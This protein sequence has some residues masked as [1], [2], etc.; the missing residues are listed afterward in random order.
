MSLASQVNLALQRIG[1]EFK[2]VRTAIAGKA[3]TLHTHIATTDLTATGTKDT[4]TYLRGDNTWTVPPNS[5]YSPQTQVEAESS[6]DTTARLTTGQRLYQA[7]AK[8][9]VLLTDARLVTQS[10][11]EAQNKADTTARV[12]T[13]QRLFQAIDFHAPTKVDLAST[14]AATAYTRVAYMDGQG[15]QN[16][17]HVTLLVTNQGNYG[18]TTRCASLIQVNQRGTNGYGFQ[19]DRFGTASAGWVWYVVTSSFIVEV[20]ALRPAFDNGTVVVLSDNMGIVDTTIATQAGAPA[21]LIAQ[22]VPAAATDTVVRVV[23]GATAG[24]AR[25]ATTYV[26]WV[27]SVSPTNATANDTWVNTSP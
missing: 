5:T 6:S 24:A 9:A 25:P 20:W 4:T 3:N 16:G 15:A 18:S 21:G 8:W 11:S 13:G 22:P 27:G 26:E 2:S 1:I 12:S 14:G 19:H 7:I 17:A 23:H 10:Q